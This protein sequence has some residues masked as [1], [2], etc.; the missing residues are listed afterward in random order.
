VTVELVHGRIQVILVKGFRRRQPAGLRQ[1]SAL[2]L[3]RQGQL[4]TG[5]SSRL[6]M[7]VEQ[8][9]LAGR[10]DPANNSSSR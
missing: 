10:A 8:A 5:K 2:G 1:P 7:S 4:G 9:P 6:K 3:L